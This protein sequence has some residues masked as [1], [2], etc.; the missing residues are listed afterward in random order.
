MKRPGDIKKEGH[1]N[2]L[3]DALEKAVY[4]DTNLTIRE[5]YG[6]LDGKFSKVHIIQNQWMNAKLEV[7]KRT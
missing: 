6:V 4:S 3:D 5:I 2:L 7:L 1:S